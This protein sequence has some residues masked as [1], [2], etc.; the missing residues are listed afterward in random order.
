[1]KKS[2]E[3]SRKQEEKKGWK[4]SGASSY[5]HNCDLVLQALREIP[6]PALCNND[7]TFRHISSQA[8]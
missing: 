4:E 1:M 3:A 5:S 7:I 6:A 8:S 2:K